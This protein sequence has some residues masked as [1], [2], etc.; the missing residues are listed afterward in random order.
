MFNIP[1]IIP[2]IAYA[3]TTEGSLLAIIPSVTPIVTPAVVPI[4]IPFFHPSTNTIKIES[5]FL[6]QNP[7]ILISPSA[8]KEIDTSKLAPKTSSIENAIFSL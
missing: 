1:A 7:N 2:E 5:I 4:S 3:A 8:H 6:I